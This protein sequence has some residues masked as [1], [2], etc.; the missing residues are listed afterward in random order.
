[1]CR[2]VLYFGFGRR[3]VLD[4]ICKIRETPSAGEAL[5]EL[6]LAIGFRIE[7]GEVCHD[8]KFLTP[9]SA[10]GSVTFDKVT[11][12]TNPISSQSP[13]WSCQI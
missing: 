11:D 8:H 10:G 13:E 6:M 3:R 5:I 9:V 7:K 4:R 2:Q 12:Q 1:M